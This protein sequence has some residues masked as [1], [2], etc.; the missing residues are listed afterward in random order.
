MN[1]CS[2]PTGRKLLI[3]QTLPK[4]ASLLKSSEIENIDLSKVICKC[5][6]SLCQEKSF[7]PNEVIKSVD[8]TV[9][10]IGEDIDSIMD[11][12]KDEEKTI[13]AE[14]WKLTNDIIN[15]LPEI[16]FICDIDSCGRKFKSNDELVQHRERRHK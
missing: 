1:L 7:W 6:I 9:S 10:N 14:L 11:V 15:S 8:E 5:L 16:S 2:S 13:L 12:A 4:L 3:K